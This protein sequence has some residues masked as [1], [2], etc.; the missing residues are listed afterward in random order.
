MKAI[1]IEVSAI[2]RFIMSVIP[3]GFSIDR[4]SAM[5]GIRKLR[6]KRLRSRRK[7]LPLAEGSE[8]RFR[9]RGCGVPISPSGEPE[10]RDGLSEKR[11]ELG[12]ELI[13]RGGHHHASSVL[14]DDQA[15]DL[16]V[17]VVADACEI[18]VHDA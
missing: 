9:E 5:K 17:A 18:V 7:D 12:P 6:P 8:G 14:A 4:I 1:A 16:S 10:S 11:S 13:A 15:C 2:R 3:L